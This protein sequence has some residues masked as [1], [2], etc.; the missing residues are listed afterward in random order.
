MLLVEVLLAGFFGVACLR[1]RIPAMSAHTTRLADLFQL[2]GRLERL[3]RSRWQW[4]SMVLVML[5]LRLQHEL[6]AAIEITAL[7]QFVIFMALPAQR[8]HEKVW[9]KNSTR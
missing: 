3:S 1:A 2:S 5:I 9:L 4:F 6:P 8:L 7:A